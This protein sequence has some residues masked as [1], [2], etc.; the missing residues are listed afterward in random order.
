MLRQQSRVPEGGPSV[1]FQD[2][3][4]TPVRN[5]VTGPPDH[6]HP[7]RVPASA[8][9]ASFRGLPRSA[10]DGDCDHGYRGDDRPAGSAADAGLGGHDWRLGEVLG[11]QPP[12]QDG[13]GPLLGA[14]LACACLAPNASSS[15]TQILECVRFSATSPL[16]WPANK[17]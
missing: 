4:V 8:A 14:P 5:D 12:Q 15:V 10:G 6:F 13:L 9:M 2:G 11:D 17:P 7:S 3:L 16:T 1:K